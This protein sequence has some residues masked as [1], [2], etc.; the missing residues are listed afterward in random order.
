MLR[1]PATSAQPSSARPVR[2]AADQYVQAYA[3]LDP[4]VGTEFGL[5]VGQD[6]LPD[7]S[8]AGQQAL[9]ELRRRTLADLGGLEQDA[10]GGFA[11]PHE[12]RCAR[13]LRERLEA[14]LAVSDTGETLRF[15]SEIFG[16]HEQVRSAFMLMPADT[17]EDWAVVARRLAAVPQALAGYRESLAEGARRGLHAAPRQVQTVA[18]QLAS[19]QAAAGGAGWFAEFAATATGLPDALRADLDRA[20]SAANAAVDQPARLAAHRLPA[21]RDR[22]AG[23]HRRGPVP[24]TRARTGPGRTWTSPRPTSGAGR[25]T[26]G[27]GPR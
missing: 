16:P 15:V 5:P 27:S 12:R 13:L 23:R 1:M 19:W 17:P 8:P 11:D 20:A 24:G 21:R 3:E 9:D 25:S 10:D 26:A 14:E 4:L 22:D 7:L 6:R 2:D 18:S